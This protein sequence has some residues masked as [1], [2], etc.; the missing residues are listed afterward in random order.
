MKQTQKESQSKYQITPHEPVNNI[1]QPD[2]VY[3]RRDF[4]KH[5]GLTLAGGVALASTLPTEKLFAAEPAAPKPIWANLV[6]LGYNMW[7][8]RKVDSWGDNSPDTIDSVTA[9]PYLRCDDKLW[10]DILAHMAKVGMNMVVIDLGEGVQ[11]KSHPELA[12][13]DS[14]ST[15]RLKKEL[16]KIRKMGI[17][18]IPKLNFSTAHDTWLGTY[19]RCVSSPTYYRVCSELIAEVAELFNKPRFFHLGYD[20]ETAGHQEKYAFAVV[21]QHELWWNDFLFFVKEVEK[22]KIRPWIWSDYF[23][24]HPEEF[25]KQMPHSVLQSNWY[26]GKSFDKNLNYVKTYLELD[27]QKFEQIPTASNWSC[28]ENFENTVAFCREHLN[29]QRLLG[30]LQTPWR[31][32]LEVFRKQHFQAID[33][34]AKVIAKYHD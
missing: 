19:A 4:F 14:W 3:S 34:V 31:P 33:L 28:P 1:N 10:N 8:D 30:F 12:V 29:P 18:P 22:H 17:E 16:N 11:Y 32:T 7:A 21:R 26:Y 15:E 5:T 2:G 25:I 6:H 9:K 23:W 20:E 27:K 13:K 24:N